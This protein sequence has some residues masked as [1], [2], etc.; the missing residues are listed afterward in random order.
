MHGWNPRNAAG[1]LDY[2]QRGELPNAAAG[3]RSFAE[4]ARSRAA[5]ESEYDS[6]MDPSPEQLEI[7]R[8]LVRQKELMWE[9]WKREH[10]E[11]DQ[12][13]GPPVP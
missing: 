1:M 8:A 9:Q 4:R 6:S 5:P 11:W 2:F 13:A 10:P 7:D 12:S 3:R